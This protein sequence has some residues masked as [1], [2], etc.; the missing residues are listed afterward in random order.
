MRPSSSSAPDRPEPARRTFALSATARAEALALAWEIFSA[1]LFVSAVVPVAFTS[2]W[3]AVLFVASLAVSVAL[4]PR[5]QRAGPRGF[6]V[7]GAL[8]A[9][10]W[11]IAIGSILELA[12]WRVIIAGAAFGLMAG[13]MRRAAY[14]RFLERGAAEADE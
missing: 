10:S 11:P 6:A 7:A 8:R 14:R 9:V 12:G 2:I 4:A 3:P 13:G 1:L 5:L